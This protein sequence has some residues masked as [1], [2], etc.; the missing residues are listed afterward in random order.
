MSEWVIYTRVGQ[1]WRPRAVTEPE[2]SE[3][4]VDE[5]MEGQSTGVA[6]SDPDEVEWPMVYAGIEGG[7]SVG[8]GVW[9]TG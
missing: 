1:L 6:R 2:V 7:R 5:G 3:L 8:E 4:A 9:E